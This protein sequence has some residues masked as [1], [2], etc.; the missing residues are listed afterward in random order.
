[1]MPGISPFNA[2]SL[3]QSL[4]NS[5]FLYTPRGLPHIRHRIRDLT[6]NFLGFLVFAMVDVFAT[7]FLLLSKGHA[8][9]F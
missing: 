5:N 6:R 1:M 8:Q 3:K 4:H 7:A 2:S 9:V